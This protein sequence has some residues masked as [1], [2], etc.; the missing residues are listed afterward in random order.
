MFKNTLKNL[1]ARIAEKRRDF[2]WRKNVKTP[3]ARLIVFEGPETMVGQELQIFSDVVRLGSDPDQVDFAFYPEVNTSISGLH[4]R[5]ERTG[6][7]WRI[8]ALSQSHSETFVNEEALPFHMPLDLYS[9]DII[10]LGY[11]DQYPVSLHFL[12]EDG[13]NQPNA[14]MAYDGPAEGEMEASL[15]GDPSTDAP[16]PQPE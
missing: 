15:P 13:L 4:A 8:E 12:T 7:R 2:S 14:E 1:L 3:L 11:V 5:L 6:G 16:P 9:G 10:R